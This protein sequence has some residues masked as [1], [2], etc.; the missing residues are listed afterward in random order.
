MANKS[1]RKSARARAA[2][3]APLAATGR[4]GRLPA[5]R[6]RRPSPAPPGPRPVL[7]VPSAVGYQASGR[8]AAGETVWEGPRPTNPAAHAFRAAGARGRPSC[9]RPA[10]SADREQAGRCLPGPAWG[11]HRRHAANT[12]PR[13]AAT[14]VS[15]RD[16]DPMCRPINS[17]HDWAPWKGSAARAGCRGRGARLP[18][19]GRRS[20]TP[21][22][23]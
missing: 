1:P 12:G 18:W 11:R 16:A 15:E 17:Y 23:A 14:A 13:C 22:S 10:A 4:I 8:P 9:L 6:R 3:G 19:P 21:G 7:W 5:A 2:R 20:E